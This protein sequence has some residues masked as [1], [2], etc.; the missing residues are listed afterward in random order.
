M[1]SLSFR[2]LLL[3]LLVVFA[4]STVFASA[5]PPTKGSEAVKQQLS[6]YF[7]NI[8]RN[9]PTVF[10]SLQ[11]SPETMKA[12]Q[13]RIAAMSDEE[14]ARLGTLMSEAPGWRSAPEM[15]AGAIPADMLEQLQGVGADL[16]SRVPEAERTRN[17]VAALIEV[18]KLLP[19]TRLQEL[20]LDRNMV[21]SLDRAFKEM[22]PLDAAALQKQLSDAGPWADRKASALASL[23]PALQKGA[24]ELARHGE[25]TPEDL[26]SLDQFRSKITSLLE[27]ID[28]LPDDTKS[29]INIGSLGQTIASLA[30]ARPEMLFMMRSQMPQETLERLDETVTLL[31]KISSFDDA[32]IAALEQFRG[33]ITATFESAAGAGASAGEVREKFASL[34]PGELYLL[35]SAMS[36]DPR[37][38]LTMP[39]IMRTIASP[40]L[41]TRVKA[42]QAP[43][44]DPQQVAMLEAFRQNTIAYVSTLEGKP[45]A[46][47]R[48]TLAKASLAQLE[49]IRSTMAA[50]P[51]DAP[52][53]TIAS[54]ASRL[55]PDFSCTIG[56]G[57][58]CLLGA[59]ASLGT[60]DLNFICNP[61]NDA[62]D[63]VSNAVTS[64]TN[65]VDEQLASVTGFVQSLID[66][67]TSVVTQIW[68]FV[69]TIPQLAWEVIKQAFDELLEI[70]I[71]G[72][73]IKVLISA[74]LQEAVPALQSALGLAGEWWNAIA[75][76]TLPTI[77]CPPAGFHTPFGDVGTGEAVDTYKQYKFFLDTIIDLIPDTEVC[78][79]VKIPAKVL[80][81]AFDF[82]GTC[83]ENAKGAADEQL[84]ADRHTTVT[85][86]LGDLSLQVGG[87]TTLLSTQLL[88]GFNALQL[89]LTNAST[90][91]DALINSE[92][93]EAQDLLKRL[94]IESS[95]QAGTAGSIAEFML[96]SR[97]GGY[98]ELVQTI[99]RETIDSMVATGQKVYEAEKFF[100]IAVALVNQASYKDAYR[101]FQKAYS[102]AVK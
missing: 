54:I 56:L 100:G 73:P 71:S 29:G 99:V 48:E 1:K 4:A 83:L 82:L 55:G 33:E 50:L 95:L 86:S 16:V 91:T 75:A 64:L 101:N 25:L 90:T 8:Q 6:A 41:Q 14:A 93:T 35:Q 68:G 39:A 5:V 81:A 69:Q 17:D 10:A 102:E 22:G 18:L 36:R 76:F 49:F 23:P 62:I 67:V 80:Y 60:L 77:P 72:V 43:E 70:E 96:P 45:A 38:Q 51:N 89:Q 74:G 34:G 65:F 27:R 12:I 87:S 47:A 21:D 97:M 84:A 58:I 66:G 28:R 3:S 88:A 78:L 32:D 94:L 19:D 40:D 9:S 57:E 31:E 24:A 20:G 85:T 98:I 79:T 53:D 26:A 52:P 44:P 46:D 92:S 15:L 11:K 2:A 7:A 37:W 13:S 59:C 42:L 30:G 63:G 61:I